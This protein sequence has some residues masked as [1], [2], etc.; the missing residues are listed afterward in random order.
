MSLSEGI[1]TTQQLANAAEA[2]VSALDKFFPET[3]FEQFFH[4]DTI[5]SAYWRALEQALLEVGK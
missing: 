3:L 5:R 1:Y 4:S 2:F